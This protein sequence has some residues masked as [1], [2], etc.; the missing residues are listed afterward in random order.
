MSEWVLLQQFTLL[1]GWT[2]DN[3]RLASSR[4]V[5]VKHTRANTFAPDTS[6]NKYEIDQLDTKSPRSTRA[7][8]DASRTSDTSTSYDTQLSRRKSI[9]QRIG[10]IFLRVSRMCLDTQCSGYTYQYK[11]AASELPAGGSIHEMPGSF[12][13]A[14]LDNCDMPGTPIY[15]RPT[16]MLYAQATSERLHDYPKENQN[17]TLL[18]AGPI[19]AANLSRLPRLEVPQPQH[20]VP[21]LI[22]DHSPLTS[23]SVSPITP[24]GSAAYRQYQDLSPQSYLDVVSPCTDTKPGQMFP[25]YGNWGNQPQLNPATPSTASSYDMSYTTT[26]ISAYGTRA[27]SSFQ[28]W[29]RAQ[30]ERPPT[31]STQAYL[32]LHNSQSLN[33]STLN[34]GNWWQNDTRV[35]TEYIENDFRF[36]QGQDQQPDYALHPQYQSPPSQTPSCFEKQSQMVKDQLL[37]EFPQS[38]HTS[39]DAPPAYSTV[40]LDPPLPTTNTQR[41]YPPAICQ[42]CGKVFTGKFGPGNRKRHVQ[43][44]HASIFERAIHACKV[45]MKTYNRADALRKHQ[46]KKHRMEEVRPIKRR[47]KSM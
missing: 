19:S 24:L 1:P 34:V 13:G 40:N 10:R 2:T 15:S 17:A 36:Y 27:E 45:C 23:P 5:A 11:G 33:D 43:H 37:F 12:P 47:D 21:R 31:F 6:K 26:P 22:S 35:Q 18:R 30:T 44:T 32:P 42:Q 14:E 46:W 38:S 3:N 29:S 16:S 25:C 9:H 39:V 4:H 20:R 41:R 8:P 7:K 28:S